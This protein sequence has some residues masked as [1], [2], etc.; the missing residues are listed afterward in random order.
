MPL[1]PRDAKLSFDQDGVI[2]WQSLLGPGGEQPKALPGDSDGPDV[3]NVSADG[4][5]V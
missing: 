2:R 4:G 3:S 1:L 5:D